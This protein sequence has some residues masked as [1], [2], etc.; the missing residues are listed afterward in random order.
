MFIDQREYKEE[1]YDGIFSLDAFN[2]EFFK[3]VIAVYYSASSGMGGPGV[4]RLLTDENIQYE[5]GMDMMRDDPFF[6]KIEKGT[7]FMQVAANVPMLERTDVDAEDEKYRKKFRDELEGWAYRRLKPSMGIYLVRDDYLEVDSDESVSRLMDSEDDTHRVILWPFG[8]IGRFLMQ[9][10][11][12]PKTY[13][14]EGTR[15]YRIHLQKKWEEYEAERERL[16]IR[17]ED[18]EW[19]PR[20]DNNC[21]ARFDVSEDYNRGVNYRGEYMLLVRAD[22]E[23][24]VRAEKFTIIPQWKDRCISEDSEIECYILY[25]KEYDS[26]GIEGPLRH[27]EPTEEANDEYKHWWTFR[28]SDVNDYGRMVFVH[29]TIEDAKKEALEHANGNIAYGGFNRENLITD[30][31][32]KEVEERIIYEKYAPYLLFLDKSDEII[33][34]ISEIVYDPHRGGHG[35]IIRELA[36]KLGISEN[37]AYHLKNIRLCDLDSASI[38]FAKDRLREIDRYDNEKGLIPWEE[39]ND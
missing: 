37:M 3:K 35:Y 27:P 24:G 16:R 39:E 8:I 1:W 19:K 31:P 34:I 38:E 20:Y 17:P 25:C 5:I 13:L 6:N 26:E 29:K 18:V 15:D 28:G 10:G 22:E 12:K 9:Y 14:Y 23:W 4:L 2:D 33:K 7:E 21:K 32:S 11:K 30:Y 36:G